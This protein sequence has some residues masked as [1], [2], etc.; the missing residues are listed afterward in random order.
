MPSCATGKRGAGRRRIGGRI[1]ISD[2]VPGGGAGAGGGGVGSTLW[3]RGF[4]T[5]IMED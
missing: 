2:R 3:D 1:Q 4:E 5:A